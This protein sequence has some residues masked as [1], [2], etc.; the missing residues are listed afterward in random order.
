MRELKTSQHQQPRP[1]KPKSPL[2]VR[3][4]ADKEADQV[5]QIVPTKQTRAESAKPSKRPST[6]RNHTRAEATENEVFDGSKPSNEKI[7]YDELYH[8]ITQKDIQI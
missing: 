7:Q 2:D 1:P 4:S 6:A 8:Q 5:P 3:E